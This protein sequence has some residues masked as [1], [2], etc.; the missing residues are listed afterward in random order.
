M[1]YQDQLQALILHADSH[2][3]GNEVFEGG[4][5]I[6]EAGDVWL[7]FGKRLAVKLVKHKFSEFP[8]SNRNRKSI[9]GLP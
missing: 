5:L 7:E 9:E 8:E 4:K 1:R 2:F 3:N 6:T